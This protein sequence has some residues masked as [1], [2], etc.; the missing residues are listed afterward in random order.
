M[1]QSTSHYTRYFKT[2]LAAVALVVVF[3]GGLHADD[4]KESVVSE[5]V[6]KNIQLLHYDPKPF[7][8]AFSEQAYNEII[9]TLDPNKQFFIQSDLQTFSVYRYHIDN[10]I[11]E[12]R[13]DFYDIIK[14]VYRER[15][16]DVQGF[17]PSLLEQPID[18]LTKETIITD[19]KNREYPKDLPELKETWKKIV[20]YQTLSAYFSLVEKDEVAS[21]NPTVYYAELEEQARKKVKKDL[22]R[23]F[24]RQLKETEEEL[25]SR[26]LNSITKLFDPHTNYYLPE[27]KED[28]DIG[29]TGTLEGIGA[30]LSEKDGQIEVVRIITGSAAWRQGELKA[31]DVILAVAQADGEPVSLDNMRVSDAVRYIRGKKGTEVRLSVKK[32]EGI[33]KIIPIVRDIVVIEETYAKD[34]IIHN[35]KINKHIGYIKLPGFYRDFKD[36]KA[37]NSSTDVHDALDRFKTKNIDGVILDLRENG[38]GALDDAWQIAGLFIPSGP[39]V[40]VKGSRRSHT[41]QDRDG[42]VSYSGPLIVLV[43][44]FS[45]SAS[46]IV[47]AAL[48]D[49]N[50]ALIVGSSHSYGKGTVQTFID[51]DS[52]LFTNDAN[53]RDLKPLGSLK[54]TIQKFF[55]VNGG[56]TQYKGVIP[57][58][59]LPLKTDYLKAGEKELD[60]SLPWTTVDPLPYKK[61]AT[62]KHYIP[63]LQEKSKARVDSSEYFKQVTTFIDEQNKRMDV[64]E[65]SLNYLDFYEND[66]KIEEESKALKNAKINAD[67]LTFDT[68]DFKGEKKEDEKK[69][70]EEW[71][72]SIQED[73]VLEEAMY[74][75]KDFI[76]ATVKK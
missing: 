65:V 52:N 17:I 8:N 22:N 38:G 45:A 62:D 18:F 51:L 50:R 27:S 72:K 63:T 20:T 11:V 1:S 60:Y 59:I 15:V 55:R 30:V 36:K 54:L 64:K 40:Q 9:K 73:A 37:R 56:S 28:F 24:E 61:W 44:Q 66:K 67:Y 57:D 74:I 21:A 3:V 58:V 68:P 7:D 48:Q 4:K 2:T 76:E 35:P 70:F 33:K 46:E 13:R 26:Y 14:N 53:V 47:A 29:I 16:V 39:I 41:Y 6:L 5:R 12:N 43:D 19:S 75:M 42:Q 32:P 49:Y 71:T 34:I 69:K 31:K 10:E 23:I 25:F